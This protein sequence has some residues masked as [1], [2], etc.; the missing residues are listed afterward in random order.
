VPAVIAGTVAPGFE[1][2]RDEFARNFRERD[3]VGAACAIYHRGEPIVDIWAG[4]RDARR[5]LPWEH[6]TTA[7][8]YSTSKGL[9]AMTI[10]LLQSRGHLDYDERV[11]HY[12]PEFAQNGKKDVTVRQLVSHQA[13][14]CAIDELLDPKL[15][16]DFDR[17]ADVLARQKPAWPPGVRWG[18]HSVSLGWYEGELVRRADPEGRTLG[19]FFAEE[20]AAPLGIEFYFGLPAEFDLDRMARM[21]EF[22]YAQFVRRLGEMPRGLVTAFLRRGSLTNRVF[23][24]P[25]VRSAGRL[26]RERWWRVESPAFGGIGTARSVARVYSAFAAG[27]EEVGLARSTF[28]QIVAPPRMPSGGPRDAVLKVPTAYSLGW[29]KPSPGFPYATSETACGHPGAGGSFGFADP[30]VEIGFA[31]VMNRMGLRLHDDPRER[32]LREAMY[33]CLAAGAGADAAPLTSAGA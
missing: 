22:N 4:Y 24:N 32:A 16:G 21:T 30:D 3:E 26:D 9:A 12:W 2:V 13:G 14:L 10:A 19:R 33:D 5:A 6:D 8:V 7:M 17:L 20:I 25:R 23:S 27:G 29:L 15:V 11:A 18:Y 31:Y 1:P 28:D